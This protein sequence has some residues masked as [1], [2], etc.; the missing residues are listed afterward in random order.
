MEA[1]LTSGSEDHLIEGL[2]FKPPSSTANYVLESRYVTYQAESGNR[3]DPVSSKVLRFRLADHGFLEA[4]SVKLAIT[5]QNKGD[6]TITPCGQTMSLFRRAR[7]FAASQLVED[8]TELA[9]ES[10]ITDRLKD[11]LRRTND[12]I[13]QHPHDAYNANSYGTLGA[14]KSRRLITHPP[15][16]ILSQDKFIPLHL[17]SSGIVMEFELDDADTAF[18]ET[19]VNFEITDVK[20]YATL[21]TIDSALANSYASHVLRGNPLHLHY[22]SVVSSRN[23]VPGSSFSISLVRGFT[24]MKQCFVILSKHPGK[25]EEPQYP[26][27]LHK[28][29]HERNGEIRADLHIF[30]QVGNRG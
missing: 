14:G 19:G 29:L 25:E 28:R 11:G 1:I 10:A 2:S 21:H 22:T 12:S 5:L 30:F 15:F 24:R 18:L 9:S 27:L 17:V 13:E 7:L 3:F 8:R 16:G 6:Q 4:S 23:L 26:S 20:L